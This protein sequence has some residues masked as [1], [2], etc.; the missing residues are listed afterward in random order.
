VWLWWHGD[1]EP[2]LDFDRV[3]QAYIRRFDI[4]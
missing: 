1:Q 3:R 2:N 4:E